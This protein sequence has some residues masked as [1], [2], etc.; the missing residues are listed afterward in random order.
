MG[1]RLNVGI[2]A[3]WR[4]LV[5]AM[6]AMVLLA[7]GAG[8]LDFDPR[9]QTFFDVDDPQRVQFEHLRDVFAPSDSLV[10]IIDPG[11]E[12]LFT[13]Q[14]LELLEFLTDEGW[15]LPWAIRVDSLVNFPHSEAVGD[16]IAIG[17]LVEEAA[18][19]DFV[20][21]ARIERVARAEPSLNG[22]LLENGGNIA[23]V[24]V[25]VMPRGDPLATS[26]EIMDAGREL[27]ARAVERFP[28]V[29]IHLGGIVAMNHAFS[30]SSVADAATLM[31]LMLLLMLAG[32]YWLLQSWVLVLATTVVMIAAIAGALGAGG[33]LGI[34][35]TTPSMVAPLI[36]LTVAIAD[37][38]HIGLG[39]QRAGGSV[40]K[41]LETSL[42][43]N[44]GPVVLTT[45]TTAVGFLS[46]NFSAVPPFR[47]LGNL[48]AVG[49]LLAGAL[50]LVVLPA[51]L[52]V[53]PHR[54][55]QPRLAGNWTVRLGDLTTAYP[56]R[57]LL[58]GGLALALVLPGLAFVRVNDDFV[59]Y[60][61]ESQPF[62][63]AAELA[64]A[65]LGGMYEIEY[66]LLAAEPGGIFDPD[67]LAQVAA[68]SAWLRAQ[69]ETAHVLTWTDVLMRLN[70]TLAGDDPAAYV[71]PTDAE[72]ASQY[73]LLYELS[74]PLGLDVTNMIAQDYGSVRLLATLSDM[75]SRRVLDF[76][77][78]ASA[79]L[80]TFAPDISE[81][82]GGINLMFAHIS[83]R[84]VEAMF[85]GNLLA[86]LLI[87]ALLAGALRSLKLAA[88]S[89]ATNLLP[90][91][92]A[93]AA[94]GWWAGD[95]GLALSTAFGMTLGIVVDDT[96]HLLS[97]YRKLR[98]SQDSA[99]AIRGTLSKVAPA[100]AITT[101]ILVVGFACLAVSTF[102][103]NAQLALITMI[104]ICFALAV[105]LL[106]L[107]AWLARFD[108]GGRGAV[109]E[110]KA[111]DR[112]ERS[113]HGAV[114]TG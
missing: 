22:R 88:I 26:Q 20:A 106:L 54:A 31:P 46:M 87:A 109:A 41:R 40:A 36:I 34:Q 110:R 1:N 79:W 14:N 76:E 25:T 95:V 94:W 42:A 24:A 59:G 15:R 17:P 47:D 5:L 102:T 18:A 58:F 38:V 103:L 112:G 98:A 69:P 65:R 39:Y 100:L 93:F 85:R 113:A 9:Y 73:T 86:V 2:R 7:A 82:H 13:P 71:L 4:V 10:F 105:D 107:P 45:L 49:V 67:W 111:A 33:W 90:V 91:A 53:L 50:S 19:L 70:R 84:N 114:S 55:R 101:V 74:L 78:R 29:E 11:A 30:E 60:F 75:D 108:G 68:F 21:I 62:R 57:L 83:E 81:R 97:R 56:R 96:V 48:V 64:D 72:L 51:L 80:A 37:C 28:D 27:A 6:F 32:L 77:R 104:T 3:P 16:D 66:Q 43:D 44:R 12:S 92:L 23:A 63:Q 52:R 61:A 8:R 89:L 99:T 35:L